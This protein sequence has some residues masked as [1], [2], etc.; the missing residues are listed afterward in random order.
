MVCV[1]RKAVIEDGERL[2]GLVE[3]FATSFEPKRESFDICLGHLV[4]DE[5]VWLA[6][7]EY[8]GALVGYCLAFDH[9]TFYA[10]GRV[11]WLE[12]IIVDQEY[13]RKG[14]GRALMESVEKWA[15]A[16]GSKLIAVATRRAAPFYA[17]I[18]YEESATFF[19]KL[20]S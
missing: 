11:A 8:D 9:Y 10:N 14:V 19:R 1:V 4:D 18:G 7:A 17:A 5:T 3:G 13:R 2:F 20:L 12:E 6:V 16:R 15:K